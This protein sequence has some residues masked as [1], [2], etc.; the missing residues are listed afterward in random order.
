MSE[1]AF[2]LKSLEDAL[3]HRLSLAHRFLAAHK[4]LL[5]YLAIVA[6]LAFGYDLVTFS[7]KAD[8]ELHALNAGAKL[9]W[10]SEGRWAMYYLNATLVPDAVMPF[11]PMLMGLIGLVTGVLFFLL[12]L[13]SQRTLSDYL[14]APVA[15]GCPMLAFGFYFTTLSYGLGVAF[16]AA[17]AGHYA[18]TRWRW[19]AAAWAI[20]CFAVAIGIYQS[21]LLL[22][23]VLFGF[24][25]IAGIIATPRLTAGVL[26]RRLGIFC[27]VLLAACAAYEAIKTI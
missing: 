7:L 24:H 9:A 21:T 4:A 3:W 22:M 18:L 19:G 6:F 11:V 13:S 26:L 5:V 12:S 25:V 15:I 23:P 2:R 10:I 27:A 8:S 16:A 14:A 20:P 1:L 17:G